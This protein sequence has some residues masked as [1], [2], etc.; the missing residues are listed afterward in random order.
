[1]LS[2]TNPLGPSGPASRHARVQVV[3][4]YKPT[5]TSIKH[6]K[7]SFSHIKV[8]NIIGLQPI[9]SMQVLSNNI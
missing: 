2:K 4:S 3:K 6:L 1:M 5:T 7:S 9:L 8:F